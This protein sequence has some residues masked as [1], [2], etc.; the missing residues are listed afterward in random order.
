MLFSK[1]YD[2]TSRLGAWLA[3]ARIPEGLQNQAIGTRRGLR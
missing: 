3:Q 2:A 1:A